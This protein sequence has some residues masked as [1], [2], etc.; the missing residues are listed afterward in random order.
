MAETKY[1]SKC[2][3]AK[4]L[5]DFDIAKG[6]KFGRKRRCKACRKEYDH[7]VHK[8]RNRA[9]YQYRRLYGISIEQVE[10]LTKRQNG[11]CAICGDG[12]RKLHVDHDHKTGR[13]RAMLCNPCNVVVGYVETYGENLEKHI[14][15]VKRWSSL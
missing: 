15:Y 7:Q 14:E 9:D 1:C 5:E 10:E 13:V 11:Q 3:I 6:G 8:K 4:P 12:T 2:G